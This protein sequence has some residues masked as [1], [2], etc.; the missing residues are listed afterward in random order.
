MSRNPFEEIKHIIEEQT[1]KVGG[2]GNLHGTISVSDVA[3]PEVKPQGWFAALVPAP[4]MPSLSQALATYTY[5]RP[6]YDSLDVGSQG[7]QFPANG[8]SLPSGQAALLLTLIR[9]PQARRVPLQIN[10]VGHSIAVYLGGSLA[11]SGHDQLV[12]DLAVGRGDTTLSVILYGGT[13]AATIWVSREVEL[14]RSEQVPDAPTVKPPTFYMI[15]PARGTFAN[16]MVWGNDPSATAWQIYRAG[17]SSQGTVQTAVNSNADLQVTVTV[18][19][20]VAPAVDTILYGTTSPLG[21]VDSYTQGVSTTDILVTY[22]ADNTLTAA[23][24]V[25]QVLYQAEDFE[26]LALVANAGHDLVTYDDYQ[27]ATNQLY[28]YQVTAFGAL[29][30]SESEF[31]PPQWIYTNDRVAPGA[32]TLGTTTVEQSTVHLNF[33]APSDLDYEGVHIYGPY[34]AAPASFEASKRIKT[35]YGEPGKIDQVSFLGGGTATTYYLPTFDALGNEQTV[36][37]AVSYAYPGPVENTALDSTSISLSADA[38]HLV[39]INYAPTDATVTATLNGVDATASLSGTTGGTRTFQMTRSE[40]SDQ[41]LIVTVAKTGLNST[42]LTYTI[43]R[44]QDAGLSSVSVA[45]RRSPVVVTAVADDD[46]NFLRFYE[47]V[48]GTWTQVDTTGAAASTTYD[49]SSAKTQTL[50]VTLASDAERTFRIDV[51]KVSA[52]GYTTR[53]TQTV[54]GPPPNVDPVLPPEIKIEQLNSGADVTGDAVGD[55]WNEMLVTYIRCTATNPNAGGITLYT[56]NGEEA[57][58]TTTGTDSVSYIVKIERSLWSVWKTRYLRVR[59]VNADGTEDERLYMHDFDQ[60]PEVVSCNPDAVYDGSNLQTGWRAKIVVDDDTQHVV[61]T[62]GS[63]LTFAAQTV[64][65]TSILAGATTA[66]ISTTNDDAAPQ[67]KSFD[68]VINQGVGNQA[69]LTLVPHKHPT[70]ATPGKTFVYSF[71]RAPVTTATWREI[72]LLELQVTLASDPSTATKYY[73]IDGG[74]WQTGSVF[75]VTRKAAADV[76]IEYYSQI[77]T[78]SEPVK[79]LTIDPDKLAEIDLTAFQA[80]TSG[81]DNRIFIDV[82]TAMDEDVATWKVWSRR[83]AWP[84]VQGG[85]AADPSSHTPSD[86]YLRYAGGRDTLSVNHYA[87]AGSTGSSNAWYVI[88]RGLDWSGVPGPLV[89]K[90]GITVTGTTDPSATPP[91]PSTGAIDNV[92][93]TSNLGADATENTSDDYHN[94]TWTVNSAITATTQYNVDIY[95][96]VE[97]RQAKTF[98]KTVDAYTQATTH[99]VRFDT[100]NGEGM[101]YIYTLELIRIADS[102]KVQTASAWNYDY[103]YVGTGGSPLRDTV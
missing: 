72:N 77:G 55:T 92:S 65:G 85:T 67:S 61:A 68:L 103:Y 93:V 10:A 94:I 84:T 79:R 54:K 14:V 50:S 9:V 11:L 23:Q 87:L 99:L 48:A 102:V 52:S 30:L 16:R 71:V 45:D 56:T 66:T 91:A 24:W 51:S 73:R 100:P 4:S 80:G 41:R 89:Y 49:V 38:N 20:L 31:S 37:S 19:A 74:T 7:L 17:Q 83:G 44:D 36:A 96:E 60:D 5:E 69:T 43:D 57:T 15:D 75:F 98:L 86:D 90:G 70:N 13:E 58:V 62:L 26:P 1:R 39:T 2:V 28:F 76:I 53:W 12:G 82:G 97:G 63:G 101:K 21:Y 27:I 6:G 3:V 59:A 42:S 40:S 35:E 64:N 78:V 95:Y 88:A 81:G 22:H 34:A 29:G 47:N 8:A 33:T 18:N 25:G 46:A 32:I